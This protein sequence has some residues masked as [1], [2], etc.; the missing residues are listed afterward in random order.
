M[1]VEWKAGWPHELGLAAERWGAPVGVYDARRRW[2]E[3]VGLAEAGT[4]T[5][6]AVQRR[7]SWTSW[8]VLA[9]LGELYEPQWSLTVH[10][11]SDARPILATLVRDAKAGR[12]QLLHRHGTAVAAVMSADRV[13]RAEP[14]AR[15]DVDA[16][17]RAGATITLTYDPGV[18]GICTPDGDVD[19]APEE[20][21]VTATAV[22]ASGGHLGAGVGFTAHE[23]LALLH[24][25]P[26]ETPITY[27]LDDEPPF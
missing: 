27:S 22:D 1:S 7:P 4:A 18:E 12:P 6:I 16:L 24:R 10:A 25:H 11:V 3:L 2:S 26:A 8:A 9:P 15:L 5:L 23:A 19:Q 17:L 21:T 14:G 20:A 13:V